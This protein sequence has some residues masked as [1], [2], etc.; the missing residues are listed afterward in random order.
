MKK[1]CLD[2][3]EDY[4]VRSGKKVP[5]CNFYDL[6]NRGLCNHDKH[7]VCVAYL[8]KN[9]ITDPWVVNFMEEFGCILC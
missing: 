7:N 5:V 6:G 2:Y 4:I 1:I 8:E 3:E 9:N